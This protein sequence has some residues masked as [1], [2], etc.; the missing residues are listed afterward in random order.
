MYMVLPVCRLC[1]GPSKWLTVLGVPRYS[2]QGT[3]GCVHAQCWHSLK[4]ESVRRREVFRLGYLGSLCRVMGFKPCPQQM[5]RNSGSIC[6]L[7]PKVCGS[8][9]S[10]PYIVTPPARGPDTAGLWRLGLWA[11]SRGGLKGV[12]GLLLL[13]TPSWCIFPSISG[14]RGGDI[15]NSGYKR[16]ISIHTY[17]PWIVFQIK[18]LKCV[19]SCCVL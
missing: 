3:T 5:G 7:A 6:P 9:A 11:P 18:L 15:T 13:H 4:D 1:I 2:S 8:P 14:Q 16:T 12:S 19:F 17:V 10:G